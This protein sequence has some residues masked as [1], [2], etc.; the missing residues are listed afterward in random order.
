MDHADVDPS[1]ECNTPSDGIV[2]AAVWL[3]DP[4]FNPIAFLPWHI[5]YPVES[6]SESGKGRG[7]A[8]QCP[9]TILGGGTTVRTPPVSRSLVKK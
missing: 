7:Y 1:A 8:G 4:G 5:Y 9:A 3:A 6:R 2:D